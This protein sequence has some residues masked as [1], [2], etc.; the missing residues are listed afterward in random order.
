MMTTF[1]TT[2]NARW[3]AGKG[4]DLDPVEVDMNFWDILARLTAVE[5]DPPDAVGIDHLTVTDNTFTVFLTSG[6]TQGPFTLPSAKFTVVAWTPLTLFAPNTFVT[7]AGNTYLVLLSHTSAASFDPNAND[8]A[9]HEFYGL[10]PFPAQPILHFLD[11][12]WTATTELHYGEIFSVPDVGVFLVLRDHTSAATFDPDAVDGSNNPMYEK[13][14]NAIE[15]EIANIQF[16]FAGTPPSDGSTI[17]VYIQ[18]DDRD[19]VFGVDFIGSFAHLEVACTVALSYLLKH[20]TSTIGTITFS[21]GELLDGAAGQ[22]GTITGTGGLIPNGEL[23][24][25][26]GPNVSDTTAQ[27]MTMA[28][29]GTYVEPVS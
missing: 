2:D 10:L 11:G 1:R 5:A 21:P 3:G 15:S 9:G 18:D 17:M 19:L 26:I 4:G 23:L 12:G 28:L 8:G 16:Q 20:G 22:F 24:K 27:F 7:E 29:R 6:A 25:L 13:L 14:F